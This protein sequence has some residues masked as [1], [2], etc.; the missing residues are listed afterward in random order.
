MILHLHTDSRFANYTIELFGPE[1]NFHLVGL[2][3]PGQKI[4]FVADHVHVGSFVFGWSRAKK[5]LTKV[6]PSMIVV[7][8]MDIRWYELLSIIPTETAVVWVFW[9]GDGYSLPKMSEN[10]YD[11]HTLVGPNNQSTHSKFDKMKAD[12]GVKSVFNIPFASSLIFEF[13][14]KNKITATTEEIK[15]AL[16]RRVDYCGTFLKEDYELLQ[17]HYAFPMEWTDARFISLERL[18]GKTNTEAPT[19]NHILLGNSCTM[20]NNHVD[21][22][23][24]IQHLEM[25]EGQKVICPL[26]YGKDLGKYRDWVLAEAEANLGD[27]FEPLKDLMSLEQYTQIL[28][29]CSYAIMYHNRQQAFNN[30]LAL[31]F[32]GVKVYLKPDN[33]IYKFLKRIGCS[34]HST[35]ELSEI[36]QLTPLA[37]S[38]VD[39]NREVLRKEF[40][41]DRI[42]E[43]AMSVMQLAIEKDG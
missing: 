1:K 35:D 34:I 26:S 11:K 18:I 13:I 21:A 15:E 32:L 43:S 17:K 25:E 39:K 8:F 38:M 40:S 9:G 27:A 10:L 16:Y 31:V 22:F 3:Y 20:E 12:L 41:Q 30:I 29:S 6:N 7:H 14:R 23:K 42:M 24:V 4:R 5:V 36:R 33:T 2:R 37:Q 28:H 19:G